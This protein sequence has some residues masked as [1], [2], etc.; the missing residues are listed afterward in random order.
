MKFDQLE[1]RILRYRNHHKGYLFSLFFFFWLF[2]SFCF[3]K[4]RSDRAVEV[5]EVYRFE[6]GLSGL[7]ILAM[8]LFYY[9]WFRPKW[10]RKVQVYPDRLRIQTSRYSHEI[11]FSE[12]DK[13]HLV[14]LSFFCIKMKSGN[15]FFFSSSLERVDYIWDGIYACCPH[16]IPPEVYKDF[17]IKLV[18]YDHHQKRKEW[19]FKHKMI[20]VVNWVIMPALLL[21]FAFLIQTHH[22]QVHNHGVYFFRLFMY[23]LLVLISTGFFYSQIL[24]KFVFD[25]QI[26]LDIDSNSKLRDLELEGMIIQRSK[27][28]QMV[29]ATFIFGLLIKY[30]LNFYTITKVKQNIVSFKVEKGSS[31]LVDNRYNCTGCTYQIHDGDFIVFGKGYI[32]QVLARE[33]DFVGQVATDKKGRNVA[34]ENV[35]EVPRGHL[36]VKAANGKDI[37]FV[38]IDDLIG[39]I[40]N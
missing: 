8:F 36:A 23:V 26:K 39:K 21:I 12:I 32:G 13:I 28:F 27:V 4:I 11:V 31:A 18:Q 16:L 35:H 2:G 25:K 33:G 5:L 6:L 38:K 3:M 10:D 40:Q 14:F 15:Q 20:D 24:K 9:F 1:P 30:D 22:I 17:R 19:F 29:T 37:I 34:S 7:L